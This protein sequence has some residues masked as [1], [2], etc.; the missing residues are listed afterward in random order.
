MLF[1]LGLTY[2]SAEAKTF[3]DKLFKN[4][5]EYALTA[6]N[7]LAKEK[8][9][10]P[11][12]KPNAIAKS[13]IVKNL[14]SKELIKNIKQY[15]LRNCSLLSIAPTGSIATM[16]QCSGGCEPEFALSYTRH[17]VNLNEDYQVYCKSVQEYCDINKTTPDNLP[18][19]FVSSEQ[20]NWKDR[21][22]T[23]GIMQKWVDTAISST[24]N[25]P[26]DTPIEEVE[27]MYLYAWQQKLKGITIFRSGCK[28]TAILSTGKTDTT[29]PLT[30]SAYSSELDLPW[31]SVLSVDN[32]LVGMKRKIIN[33]CGAFHI[34]AFYDEE[35]GRIWETF[36][37]IG[38][39]GGCERNL[40][41]ISKLISKCLRAGVPIDDVINTAKSGRPCMSYCNRT[42]SK[43]DTSPGISC[44]SAIGKALEDFKNKIAKMGYSEYDDSDI[45][46]V[47]VESN[48]THSNGILCPECGA[49][50]I[51][52]GGCDVCKSCGYSHCG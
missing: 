37:N 16:M 5:F 12:C 19:Y 21:I 15:G 29:K 33:G 6:S 50:M 47:D 24:I 38:D 40:E 34:Q 7:N 48:T 36:I 13:T 51:H 18:E 20:I 52:E 41:F 1:E 39:G 28:R 35:E 26:E 14:G 17:T 2:G 30:V 22:E 46:D 31:G 23:Q 11:K 45:I 49:Q 4:M 44:P 10:F 9:A 32:D 43:G 3:T 8:G 27:Q 42:K 25:L